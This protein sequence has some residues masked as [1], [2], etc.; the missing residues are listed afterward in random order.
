MFRCL[1]CPLLWRPYILRC[2]LEFASET[3]AVRI[4]LEYSRIA[5]QNLSSSPWTLKGVSLWPSVT[6]RLR[7]SLKAILPNGRGEMASLL[8]RV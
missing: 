1:E 8:F 6:G 5:Y 4:I 7:S 2:I 3:E